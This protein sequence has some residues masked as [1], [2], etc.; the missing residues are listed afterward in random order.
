MFQSEFN[1]NGAIHRRI[2]KNK[3]NEV[4]PHWLLNARTYLIIVNILPITGS[5]FCSPLLAFTIP[6]TI[7][8]ITAT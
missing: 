8:V 6:T 4:N 5:G 7:K 3:A 1:C 2:Q